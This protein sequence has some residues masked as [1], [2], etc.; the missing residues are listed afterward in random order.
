[1]ALL[2]DVTGEADV[3]DGASTRSK[4]NTAVTTLNS[5]SE[6]KACMVKF[7]MMVDSEVGLRKEES[8]KGVKD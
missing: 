5:E 1:V 3:W 2:T 6:L 8:S 4:V 7:L